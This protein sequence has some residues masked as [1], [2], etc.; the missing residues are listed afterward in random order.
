MAKMVDITAKEV[1]NLQAIQN[2][3]MTIKRQNK[4]YSKSRQDV[5]H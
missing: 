3:E 1:I 2:D 5:I 4:K